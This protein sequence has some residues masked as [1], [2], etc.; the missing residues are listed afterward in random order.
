M[1]RFWWTRTKCELLYQYPSLLNLTS[2]Y[3]LTFTVECLGYTPDAKPT[4]VCAADYE[5]HPWKEAFYPTQAPAAWNLR[6]P[7]GYYDDTG[8]NHIHRGVHGRWRRSGWDV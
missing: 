7:F 5:N 6:R 2:H 8:Y 1:T 3:L 4:R